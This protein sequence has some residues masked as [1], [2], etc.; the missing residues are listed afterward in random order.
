MKVNPV[1]SQPRVDYGII[2]SVGILFVMSVVALFST[3]VLINQ[4]TTQSIL[5]HVMWYVVGAILIAMIMQLDSKQIWKSVPYLYGIALVLL[6]LVL[7]FHDRST[8]VLTGAKS[9]FK[10]GGISFQPS[11]LSKIALI[12]ML[13]LVI[14]KHNT[15][16]RHTKSVKSDAKLLLQM[17][18]FTAPVLCLVMLQNDLGTTLVLIS[19]F[20][21]L[22]L[23]SGIS[24]RILIP[25]FLSVATI[26]GLLLYLV[27][28]HREWLLVFGFKPYQF[29]RIDAW[30]N[31]FESGLQSSY[32]I[33][34]SIL[35]I[36]TGEM[37]GKGLGVT[38]VHVPVRSSDMIFTTI[39]ENF[40]FM[41]SL[42]LIFIYCLLIYQM[43]QVCFHTKNEFYTYISAGVISM[44]V[45]HVFENVG[46]SIGLLPLT[47]IPLPF[48]SQ[49]GSALVVNMIGVGLVLAMRYQTDGY[50]KMTL[51]RK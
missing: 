40:G 27:V 41:G 19:I 42:L 3:T 2:L 43:I 44:I 13:S 17:A 5:L 8:A 28:Y 20:C 26:G 36:A 35:A 24:A 21:G 6:V 33:Q 23:M 9:W 18:L 46:M 4:E 22:M 7:F 29:S 30:L 48:I 10:I 31:P 25:L 38:Q 37:F 39:A 49:G 32:Q 45:F 12:L 34:N 47:G 50:A 11:E 1:Q 16:H 15:M 14:T 51:K